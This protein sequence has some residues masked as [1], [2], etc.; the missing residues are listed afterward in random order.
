MRYL[1][2]FS[3]WNSCSHSPK[4]IPSMRCVEHRGVLRIICWVQN[5]DDGWFSTNLLIRYWWF[6]NT[7]QLREHYSRFFLTLFMNGGKHGYQIY[8]SRLLR[9]ISESFWC[10]YWIFLML[11][12]HFGCDIN[13]WILHKKNIW[14]I[15][16]SSQFWCDLCMFCDNILVNILFAIEKPQLLDSSCQM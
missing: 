10:F 5:F 9:S 8:A 11:L 3:G 6:S 15:C 12:H 14:E 7:F 2:I 1:L 4:H 13:C 16:K